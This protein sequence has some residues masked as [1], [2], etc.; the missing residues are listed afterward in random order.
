MLEKE[1]ERLKQEVHTIE[2]EKQ[3]VKCSVLLYDN[4]YRPVLNPDEK[5]LMEKQEN[6]F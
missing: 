2:K 6:I 5:I 4:N 1:R 3:I